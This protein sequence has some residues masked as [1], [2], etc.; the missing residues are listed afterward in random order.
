M[1]PSSL[2]RRLAN[3]KFILGDEDEELDEDEPAATQGSRA[4]P[5][6]SKTADERHPGLVRLGWSVLQQLWL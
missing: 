6:K 5:Q 4:P 3:R 1:V 2:I